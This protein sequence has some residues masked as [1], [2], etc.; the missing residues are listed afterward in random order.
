MTKKK[1]TYDVVFQD[2]NNSNAKGFDESF[3]FCQMYVEAYN[4]TSESYFP[5]YKGG[6]V[7]VVCNQTGGVVYERDV[8]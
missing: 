1:H 7:Q 5:D 8:E 2:K 6:V 3:V 4:G